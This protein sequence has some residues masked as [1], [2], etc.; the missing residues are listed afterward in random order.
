MSEDDNTNG[1]DDS[2]FS[3]NVI[4]NHQISLTEELNISVPTSTSRFDQCHITNISDASSELSPM[5]HSLPEQHNE[6]FNK[7][8]SNNRDNVIPM[9]SIATKGTSPRR[10]SDTCFDAAVTSTNMLE[11]EQEPNYRCSGVSSKASSPLY[12]PESTNFATNSN[13]NNENNLRNAQNQEKVAITLSPD[14]SGLELLSNSI[15]AFEKNRFIKQE[16]SEKATSPITFASSSLPSAANK[17]TDEC[18][19][20]SAAAENKTQPELIESA[21]PLGGLNLL[22]ALAEQ[23]FQEEVGHRSDRKRSSSSDISEPKRKKHKHSS[24]KAKKRE[25]KEKKRRGSHLPIEGDGRDMAVDDVLEKDLKD[26]YDRVKGKYLKCKCRRD[27]NVPDENCCCRTGT[28]WPSA[29]EVYS[30]MKTD[31]RNRLMEITREVQQKKRKLEA[32]NSKESR[33]HRES[34]P[35]SLKSTSSSSKISTSL[36]TL[37]PSV[38]STSSLD[39]NQNSGNDF[40]TVTKVSSDTD[41][42][43]SN[44]GKPE[45]DLTAKKNTS[46]VGYIFAS[47]KRQNDGNFSTTDEASVN[48]DIS[49]TLKRVAAIKQESFEFEDSSSVPDS[50][51]NPFGGIITEDIPS[52]QHI[53]GS[54]I[55]PTKEH[56][57]KHCTSPKH[58]K[59][60]KSNKE[61]KRHRRSSDLHERKRLIDEKCALTAEHLDNLVNKP[62]QRVLTAMGGLFYAGSLN[63]VQPPDVYAVKLDGE[64]GNRP[65]ILSREEI[66]RDAVR[67]AVYSN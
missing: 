61:K 15:E 56:K 44:S 5:F 13:S 37:S 53:F 31:M 43:S 51:S 30:A 3:S 18:Q 28:N 12:D 52:S 24:K 55:F 16:P 36:P 58:H 47:K 7:K 14:I 48:S 33:R 29:E 26:T 6:I 25:R 34:T 1:A 67:I 17:S 35:S 21:Q 59:K 10:P 20:S 63:A 49:A 60:T 40:A 8:N 39:C 23:R 50:V 45:V 65:H 64:R 2:A 57:K 11:E 38:L 66:L 41:S 19:P 62:Q 46:L 27:D 9:V 4:I 42:S 22:C 54:T 32:M